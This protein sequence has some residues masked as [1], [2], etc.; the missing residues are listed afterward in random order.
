MEGVS[1]IAWYCPGGREDDLFN[2]CIAFTNLHG[3]ARE[4][5]RQVQF[6]LEISTV[7]VI[8]M[9]DCD[10]NDEA[11]RILDLCLTSA[12]PLLCLCADK[13]RIRGGNLRTKVKI[14]VKNRNEAELTD[15]LKSTL[16]YVGQFNTTG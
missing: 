9:S 8:L 16:K 10:N 11:K 7:N 2:D 14:A 6:L 4:H 13:E 3:D 15:E 12:K 5:K 1:E